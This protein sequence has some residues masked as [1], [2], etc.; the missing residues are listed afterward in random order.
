[1]TNYD[2]VISLSNLLARLLWPRDILFLPADLC[3]IG[4]NNAFCFVCAHN[5]SDTRYPLKRRW[6]RRHKEGQI[7]K[8]KSSDEKQKNKQKRN[9]NGTNS[10]IDPIVGI[11]VNYTAGWDV[12]EVKK[13]V[14]E[15]AWLNPRPR[16]VFVRPAPDQNTRFLR[17]RTEKSEKHAHTPSGEIRGNAGPH[18]GQVYIS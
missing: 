1:M 11:T 18:S 10:M 13:M 4:W 16:I 9:M 3:L 6:F 7:R 5:P 15:S 2:K 12:E 8:K 17:S 14:E